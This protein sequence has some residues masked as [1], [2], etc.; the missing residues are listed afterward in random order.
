MSVTILTSYCRHLWENPPKK[1]DLTPIVFAYDPRKVG[2][3][4]LRLY[5]SHNATSDF[6]MLDSVITK[7][8][9]QTQS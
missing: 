2:I 1:P 5:P 3:Y 9:R 7:D 4:Y 6:R 8:I